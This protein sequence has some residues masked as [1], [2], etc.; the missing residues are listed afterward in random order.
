[1][2]TSTYDEAVAV[3]RFSAGK[4]NSC[5]PRNLIL[6]PLKALRPNQSALRLPPCAMPLKEFYVYFVLTSLM[7][8]E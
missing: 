3:A 6:N 1:M 8:F 7:P 2:I 5:M 4:L